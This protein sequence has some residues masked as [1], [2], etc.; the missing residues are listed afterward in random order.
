MANNISKQR[1]RR[2]DKIA[3]L[4]VETLVSSTDAISIV[5]PIA[6]ISASVAPISV[7]E[8]ARFWISEEKVG[9]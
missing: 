6:D 1:A 9:S 7:V 8:R 5:P 4:I 2:A 3:S